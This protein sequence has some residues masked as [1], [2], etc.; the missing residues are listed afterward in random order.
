MLD[1]V[2]NSVLER[3]RGQLDGFSGARLA[4][5]RALLESA[6]SLATCLELIEKFGRACD[7]CP[8]CA[9]IRIH[10]NTSFRWRHRFMAAARHDRPPRL[11]GIV[12]AEETYLLESQKGSRYLDRPARRAGIRHE[13]ALRGNGFV[14]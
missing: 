2:F 5:L 3:L 11:Q 13:A 4:A 12:E 8:H 1:G 7:R 14:F 9:T 10:R 6:S